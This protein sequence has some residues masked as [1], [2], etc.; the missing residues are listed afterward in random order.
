VR[1]VHEL[2]VMVVA[3]DQGIEVLGGRRVSRDDQFLSLVD[4]HLH[5]RARPQARLVL[6][7]PSLRYQPFKALLFHG[8]DQPAQACIQNRGIPDRLPKLG[9]HV[10]LNQLPALS[11]SLAYGPFGLRTQ[12]LLQ[13]LSQGL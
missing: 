8:A 9:Q 12:G 11:Q 7:V 3:D 4:P 1:G 5:P 10:L 2:A 6:A 13:G